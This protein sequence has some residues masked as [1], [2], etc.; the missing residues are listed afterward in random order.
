MQSD[1]SVLGSHDF[2][3][4]TAREASLAATLARVRLVRRARRGV[5]A[6]AVGLVAA[7]A[8]WLGMPRPPAITSV[9]AAGSPLVVKSRSLPATQRIVSTPR[10]DLRT[11][12]EPAPVERVSTPPGIVVSRLGEIEFNT[13]LAANQLYCIQLAGDLPQVLPLHP[14]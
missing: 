5:G 1:P 14:E 8:V 4:E 9:P 7:G 10:P 11:T 6:G 12:A 2:D 13:L 3:P